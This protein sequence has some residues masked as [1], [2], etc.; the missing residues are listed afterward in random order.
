LLDAYQGSALGGMSG[1]FPGNAPILNAF[2]NGPKAEAKSAEPSQQTPLYPSAPKAGQEGAVQ[3]PNPEFRKLGQPSE[4][5]A[6]ES[7]GGYGTYGTPA[8]GNG[9]YG[10]QKTM[11]VITA[12]SDALSNSND[13]TPLNVG[14]ISLQNGAPFKPHKGHVN[15]RDVDVRPVRRDKANQPVTWQSPLYDRAATQRLVDAFRAT[16]QVLDIFFNDPNIRGVK[17]LRDHDN[18][19]HIV[20]KP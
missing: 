1:T 6:G 11:E 5:E 18:H 2:A 8:D 13:Y 7:G 19:L 9:Q 3:P 12:V 16:G 14:N 20:I 10:T 15:G 4:M 17:P